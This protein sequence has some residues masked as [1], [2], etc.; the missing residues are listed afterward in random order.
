[1]Q[2]KGS[3]Y[4]VAEGLTGEYCCNIPPE[5]QAKWD[6]WEKYY[7]ERNQ[8]KIPPTTA[9]QQIKELLKLTPEQAAKVIDFSIGRGYQGLF[10][11]RALEKP[12]A[13]LQP[14]KDYTGV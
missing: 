9:Y 8:R 7:R 12:A 6:E 1:M 14:A 4:P 2:K 13:A 10:Y 3:F 11:D 5:Y